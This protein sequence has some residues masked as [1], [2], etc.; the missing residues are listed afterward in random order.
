MREQKDFPV[1]I[2]K[3]ARTESGKAPGDQSDS[4]VN[5]PAGFDSLEKYGGLPMISH[6]NILKISDY[7]QSDYDRKGPMTQELPDCSKLHNLP[8]N[9]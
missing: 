3:I 1:D 5:D 8:K 9:I 6:S 2:T 7:T 4:C